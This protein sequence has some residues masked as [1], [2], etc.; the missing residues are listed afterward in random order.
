VYDGRELR[1]QFGDRLLELGAVLLR[2]LED[3]R[4]T[5]LVQVFVYV[6]EQ[7]RDVGERGPDVLAGP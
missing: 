4:A 3:G 2:H 5:R 1:A 7:L 6:S